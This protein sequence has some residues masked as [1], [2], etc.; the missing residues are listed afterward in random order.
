MLMKHGAPKSKCTICHS[1][2]LHRLQSD[3][4]GLEPVF[5]VPCRLRQTSFRESRGRTMAQVTI[6]TPPLLPAA[7]Q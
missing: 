1:H 6:D 5:A 7:S 2:G 3:K 4:R